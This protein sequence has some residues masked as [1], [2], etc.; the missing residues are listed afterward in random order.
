MVSNTMLEYHD[1]QHLLGFGV[2]KPALGDEV[3]DALGQCMYSLTGLLPNGGYRFIPM[4]P[5]CSSDSMVVPLASR[6]ALGFFISS[7]IMVW[8]SIRVLESLSI[9]ILKHEF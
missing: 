6:V 1:L 8:L 2:G 7:S 5:K 4:G 9:F 3:G